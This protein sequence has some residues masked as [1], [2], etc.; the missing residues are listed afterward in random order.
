VA[1]KGEDLIDLVHAQSGF[2]AL[3]FAQE[4]QTHARAI[5]ERYLRKP[6]A[7][8]VV[9]HESGQAGRIYWAQNQGKDQSNPMQLIPN[10]VQNQGEKQ[11]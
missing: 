10:R 6:Q 9:P 2:A 8:A 3:Q 11:N 4:T 1:K 7:L 5:R